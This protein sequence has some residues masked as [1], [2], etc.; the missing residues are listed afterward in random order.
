MQQRHGKSC[1]NSWALKERYK[2]KKWHRGSCTH[3][4]LKES[5]SQVKSGVYNRCC[6]L[7]CNTNTHNGINKRKFMVILYWKKEC[8]FHPSKFLLLRYEEA[9]STI[10]LHCINCNI[11]GASETVSCVHSERRQCLYSFPSS[12]KVSAQSTRGKHTR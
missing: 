10:L 7:H 11:F 9:P 2:M 6:L 5:E 12:K 4:T 3:R 1:R 8:I